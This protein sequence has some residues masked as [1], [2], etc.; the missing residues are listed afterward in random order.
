MDLSTALD[1]QRAFIEH[2]PDEPGLLAAGP[3]TGKTWVLE[4]RSEFLTESGVDPS[5]VAVLTLTRSLANELSDRIPHGSASTLHS[6]ALRHLNL[7]RDAWGKVVV[8]PW[9]Q[10]EIVR[11]DLSLGYAIS[12]GETCGI[13]AVDAFLKKMAASFREDQDSPADL[14]TQEERLRQVFIQHRE[15]FAYRLMDEL[16]YDLIRLI[17]AGTD[18]SQ[19]PTHIIVDEYQD[20]TAGELRLLQLIRE[21]FGSPINA[22]GD[23]RQSIYG[24]READERALH[25]FVDVY[26]V[27]QPN[28]LWR[29]SRCPR[30]ICD[31]ANRVASDLPPLPGLERPDLE[32]WPGRSD[33]GDLTMSSYPSP[34]SEARG[35]VRQC[36]ELLDAGVEPPEIVVVV[37][38][39]YGPVFSALNE[40]A[41]EAGVPD[42]FVD[43]RVS[44]SVATDEMR[45]AA[46]CARLLIDKTDQMAWRTLVWLTPSLGHTRLRRILEADGATYSNRLR[47]MAD[48]DHVIA[49]PTLAG[50]RILEKFGGQQEVSLPDLV[51]TAAEALGLDVDQDAVDSLPQEAIKPEDVAKS[52][53]EADEVIGEDEVAAE[54]DEAIVVHTIFSAKGLQAPHV[55]LVNAVNESFAGRGDVA[56]GLRRTYVGITRASEAL[57]ISGSRYLK[58]T[59]LG[60][61]MGVTT[62]RPADFLVDQCAKV[63]V[64]LDV[65]EAGG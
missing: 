42:L 41:L 49:R 23:D 12:F 63:G 19:P 48:R 16:A 44:E 26:G 22:A 24:F 20:L 57:H 15:L 40:A 39:Y 62:S 46:A 58:Y 56:D 60:N 53:F 1:E 64:A 3:G 17:E 43:P 55:F 9:E 50:D 4:R 2:P 11:T 14:S 61:Q 31:L 30:R 18:L 21:R 47:Y 51:Q 29:S 34:V 54:T 65:V 25:R 35:V 45:L 8:N 59:A 6:F 27:G 7:L 37:A 5:G 10:R 36:R 13:S 32:P 38:A 33:E 28:Y 52:L